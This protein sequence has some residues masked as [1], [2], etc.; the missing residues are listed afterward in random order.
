MQSKKHSSLRHRRMLSINKVISY[1][2]F[3]TKDFSHS[4]YNIAEKSCNENT[5]TLKVN[6][7]GIAF[8]CIV[9]GRAITLNYHRS[10]RHLRLIDCS[11]DLR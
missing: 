4:T 1:G 10:S 7:C 11:M 8:Y 5:C 6:F 9:C 3:I 2:N